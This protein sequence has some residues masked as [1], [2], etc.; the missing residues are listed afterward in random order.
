MKEKLKK[1]KGK[2]IRLN[3]FVNGYNHSQVGVIEKT[4]SEAFK[5][6]PNE[7]NDTLAL[8]YNQ[9]EDFEIVDCSI[10]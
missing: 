6:R 3:Y 9:V 7:Y 4:N 2:M 10:E 1:L 5:F 8:S